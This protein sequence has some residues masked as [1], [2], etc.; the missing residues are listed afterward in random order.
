[1][2]NKKN[3]DK[4]S[5]RALP[6]NVEMLLVEGARKRRQFNPGDENEKLKDDGSDLET[7]REDMEVPEPMPQR[8]RI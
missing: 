6:L 2:T 7:I 5:E 3:P 4:R 8:K 1:M